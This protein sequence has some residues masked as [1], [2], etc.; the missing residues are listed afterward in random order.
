M[1]NSKMFMN[2]ELDKIK[3][4]LLTKFMQKYNIN[5]EYDARYLF[6]MVYHRI[7]SDQKDKNIYFWSDKNKVGYV[8]E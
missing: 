3:P 8:I 5:N 7:I 2:V 4:Q 1:E 6:V